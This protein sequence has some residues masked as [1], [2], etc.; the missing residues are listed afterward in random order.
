MAIQQVNVYTFNVT[1]KSKH[2]LGE[3]LPTKVMAI[4]VT[5]AAAQAVIQQQFGPDL[6]VVTGGVQTNA[7]PVFTTLA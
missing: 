3:H 6:G 5:A 1:L 7:Q 2:K 4:G